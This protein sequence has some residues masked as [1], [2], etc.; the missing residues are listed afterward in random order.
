MRGAGTSHYNMSSLATIE[1]TKGEL[2]S[3]YRLRLS[4]QLPR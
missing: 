3:P 2:I 1:Q 4:W